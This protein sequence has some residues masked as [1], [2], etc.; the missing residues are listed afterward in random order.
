MKEIGFDVFGLASDVDLVV[1]RIDELSLVKTVSEQLTS[2]QFLIISALLRSHDIESL[3]ATISPFFSFSLV[4]S[5]AGGRYSMDGIPEELHAL[6]DFIS[7]ALCN[8]L[9]TYIP[10][11]A[12]SICC[13]SVFLRNTCAYSTRTLTCILH[14]LR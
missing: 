3:R 12:C 14:K 4:P 11:L 5:V 7:N 2:N 1:R 6:Q 8:S 10:L 13:C 9:Q